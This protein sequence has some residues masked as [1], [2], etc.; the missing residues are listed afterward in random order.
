MQS[1]EANKKIL[2]IERGVDLMQSKEP[3]HWVERVLF[4]ELFQMRH[5]LAE[6]RLYP[7]E[8]EDSE[9]ALALLRSQIL[10]RQLGLHQQ[11]RK[12]LTRLLRTESEI[13]KLG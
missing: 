11:K 2:E 6:R 4:Q 5:C 3:L 1:L 8:C 7:R 13:L 9:S 10:H 12:K